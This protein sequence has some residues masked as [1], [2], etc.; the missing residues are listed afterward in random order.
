MWHPNLGNPQGFACFMLQAQ[1]P[2]QEDQFIVFH[3]ELGQPDIEEVVCYILDREVAF[4]HCCLRNVRIIEIHNLNVQ[5]E[6][7]RS[8][9]VHN[10]PQDLGNG[11]VFV[12]YQARSI[13]SFTELDGFI[14][15][16]A[17]YKLM[18]DVLDVKLQSA[19]W[20]ALPLHDMGS[21]PSVETTLQR[22]QKFQFHEL[23]ATSLLE[24][25]VHWW[26]LWIQFR[27]RG[28][29]DH[30]KAIAVSM[31]ANWLC[32]LFGVLVVQSAGRCSG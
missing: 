15:L 14:L 11:R 30:M 26:C 32:R 18:H 16:N 5:L 27:K 7:D 28:H 19:K 12:N 9:T 24:H 29:F 6:V 13:K 1:S 4:E 10:C 22:H 17:G 3:Q 31:C 21:I 2:W 8:S 23:W 20:C 25:D